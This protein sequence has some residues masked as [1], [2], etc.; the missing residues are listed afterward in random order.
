MCR[1]R[2][3]RLISSN[4]IHRFVSW[5]LQFLHLLFTNIMPQLAQGRLEISKQ[6]YSSVG[7]SEGVASRCEVDSASGVVRSPSLSIIGT[8]VASSVSSI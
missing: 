6:L 3:L 8:G 1:G 2:K 4:A 7:T 5:E